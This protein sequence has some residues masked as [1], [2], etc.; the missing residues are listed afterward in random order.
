MQATVETISNLERRLTVAMPLQPIEEEIGKRLN[1][2]ARTAKLPGFRPGKV[3]YKLVLQQYGAG[4]RQEVISSKVEETFSEAIAKHDLHIVGYPSIEPK[5]LAENA[6][7]YEYIATFEVFP[8]VVVGD[9][10]GIKVE[11][12]TV[13]LTDADVDKTIE[14]MRKQRTVFE[15][16]KRA[17][18]LEDQISIEF[19]SNIDGQ[20][21][22]NT[23]GQVIDL[24][25]GEQGRLA[26]FDNNLVGLKA[27]QSK[28]FKLTFP[29]DY[30]IADLT[31]KTAS[32]D[33]NVITVSA[34][35]LPEVDADFARELGVVDGDV[36]K[37][38]EEIRVSLE[39]E[40]ERR[41]KSLVKQQVLD[42]LVDIVQL[43][44]PRALVAA[45]S[46]K[47]LQA[48]VQNAQQR[49]VDPAH[50]N[51]NSSIFEEQAKR[52]VKLRMIL[53][54]IVRINGLQ[55]KPE[56]I[57]AAID[58]FAQSFEDPAEVVA[59]YHADPQRL[60]EPTAVATEENAINWVLEQVKV[61]N[62]NS[63]FDDLMGKGKA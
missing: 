55:A 58:V 4:V 53:T 3:P 39:Q 28:Q 51:L 43:E 20:E 19:T 37:M 9:L 25:L 42:G 2:L 47:Q 1:S 63:S 6:D 22:E 52:G 31:G 27:G 23:S 38:R 62:K 59:W 32:Y 5:P 44:L 45:E 13:K 12:P 29:A 24:I 36:E 7:S 48:A 41:I 26:D 34:P 33:I 14:V 15:P 54:E 56:Q 40:V 49:G 35:K 57:R 17:A 8:E 30:Q 61:S 50:L 16:V 60:D 18:K 10:S 21:V 11:R 46:N